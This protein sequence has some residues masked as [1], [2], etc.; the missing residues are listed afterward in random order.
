MMKILQGISLLTVMLVVS[1][2]EEPGK[3]DPV[4]KTPEEIFVEAIN[5]KN[6]WDSDGTELTAGIDENKEGTLGDGIYIFNSLVLDSS[7]QAIYKQVFG[8]SFI[9]IEL[10]DENKQAVM[11][12]KGTVETW[13]SVG[14]VNFDVANKLL[15]SAK[16]EWI[17]N[18]QAKT[19][20]IDG[21]E[22][23]MK[24][25]GN[26]YLEATEEGAED[27]LTFT[28]VAQP[29]K[30]TRTPEDG[31]HRD[32]AIYKQDNADKFFGLL[33]DDTTKL[34]VYKNKAT[35]FWATQAE[36]VFEDTHKIVIFAET[37]VGKVIWDVTG[38]TLTAGYDE[39]TKEG[40]LGRSDGNRYFF[41]SF[42]LENTPL[43]AIYTNA[44]GGFIGV[45][46]T[47]FT[48]DRVPPTE[49]PEQDYLELV[50]YQKGTTAAWVNKDNVSFE[51][52]HKVLSSSKGEW[53]IKAIT[54]LTKIDNVIY[55]MK[56]DGNL[57]TGDTLT[58]SYVANAKVPVAR[59][60]NDGLY[61]SM[62]IY[63]KGDAEFFG[64]STD[65]H[66]AKAF[67]IVYRNNGGFWATADE[68]IFEDANIV[69]K[70]PKDQ[71]V[72]DSYTEIVLDVQDKELKMNID[73]TTGEGT[74]TDGTTATYAFHSL[75]KTIG[76]PD[77]DPVEKV[78]Y[79]AIYTNI[80]P[81]NKFIGVELVVSSVGV[82]SMAMYKE[83]GTTPWNTVDN[84]VFH[85][86]N[87]TVEG[88]RLVGD[89]LTDNSGAGYASCFPSI[90]MDKSGNLYAAF[91]DNS[92]VG[93]R[94]TSVVK[95]TKSTDSWDF[96]GNQKI[97]AFRT[98][99]NDIVVADNGNVFVSYAATFG[100]DIQGKTGMLKWTGSEWIHFGDKDPNALDPTV[101]TEFFDFGTTV[102]KVD[103]NM[104]IEGN[105]I[106]A[107]SSIDKNLVVKKRK[108]DGSDD[109][110]QVGVA[111]FN[112]ESGDLWSSSSL[113]I[114][115]NTQQL[116]VGVG[117]HYSGTSFG[118]TV[119][120]A[121]F[122]G[123]DW[124]EL[125]DA[126]TGASGE[127][128]GASMHSIAINNQGIV[129]VA[130]TDA[131]SPYGGKYSHTVKKYNGSTWELVGDAGF[132]KNKGDFIKILFYS[133]DTPVVTI[134]GSGAVRTVVKA[135]YFDNTS[136]KSL[137]ANQ[138]SDNPF[139]YYSDSVI[140]LDDKFYTF[141][142]SSKVVSK[143]NPLT[144]KSRPRVN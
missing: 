87:T 3:K 11:Y 33:S 69:A 121:R 12:K 47:P 82:K 26:L 57:Y 123:T 141:F 37:I 6:I 46:Y 143:G 45:K 39:D 105:F 99:M 127:K 25:D 38:S 101:D 8:N 58:F 106:Y 89:I 136:W 122:D 55:T 2:S 110:T 140:G 34:F 56:D 66:N 84:V 86:D 43:Q 96:L 20:R 49:G 59:T 52:A 50:M 42:D 107:V 131:D 75:A 111:P 21:T 54:L 109:W 15:S 31:L 73:L 129:Y 70:T 119:R 103:P 65:N 61:S 24:N 112:E 97:S 139:D 79:Q 1:C 74:I 132:T 88:W 16:G 10:F 40:V 36:V 67:T 60:P 133:D 102:G 90:T 4:Q 128:K 44:T 63:K 22:Y 138:V 35:D 120:V 29:L 85:G 72:E 81:A 23:I 5:E 17:A 27:V 62:V 135:Y 104:V 91:R 98:D 115:P 68:V 144:V 51:D 48:D 142:S 19:I 18:A 95:Y 94:L 13:D 80:T 77:A 14:E 7:T 118:K 100:S 108:T 113:V 78:Q 130:Y 71:F 93:E 83:N 53:V 41:E 116:V 32:R 125:G 126:L 28:H 134:G 64:L 76:D 124:I 9:G 30:P 92:K 114:D 117:S 137:G